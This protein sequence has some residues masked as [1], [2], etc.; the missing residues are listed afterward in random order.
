MRV[1]GGGAEQEGE[2]TY[3][4]I[5]EI[6]AALGKTPDRRSARRGSSENG[7]DDGR[8]ARTGGD[9]GDKLSGA[10]NA[11]TARSA[12]GARGSAA[13]YGPRSP[14]RL[15]SQPGAQRRQQKTTALSP[16]LPYPP[17]PRTAQPRG[18]APHRG[19]GC[20]APTCAHP[21]SRKCFFI[22]ACFETI[23]PAL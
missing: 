13:P 18:T 20:S 22:N 2:G 21:P 11:L 1:R 16:R 5:R 7:G 23:P 9:G 6:I 10:H 15:L 19:R 4:S 12:S 3:L 17:W 14:T 8:S